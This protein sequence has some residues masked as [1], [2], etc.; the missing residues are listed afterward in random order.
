MVRRSIDAIF[1]ENEDDTVELRG[2]YIKKMMS[3]AGS[4]RARELVALLTFFLPLSRE[5]IVAILY[6]ICA[7]SA[8]KTFHGDM[9]P[10][11]PSWTLRKVSAGVRRSRPRW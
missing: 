11:H 6:I 2:I 5:K 8:R 4:V 9:T 10:F 7:D 3:T 1:A